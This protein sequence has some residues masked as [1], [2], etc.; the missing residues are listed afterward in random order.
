MTI[1]SPSLKYGK[2][3][4]E[5]K[6]LDLIF[7]MQESLGKEKNFSKQFKLWFVYQ[8]FSGSPIASEK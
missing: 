3:N 8:N 6:N 4:L 5:S 1:N 7:P 2:G